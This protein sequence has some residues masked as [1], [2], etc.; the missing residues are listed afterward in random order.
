MAPAPYRHFADTE[1]SGSR[2]IAAK[3]DPEDAIM[4]ASGDPALSQS[5]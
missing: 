5:Q 1:E 3:H 4:P 2:G